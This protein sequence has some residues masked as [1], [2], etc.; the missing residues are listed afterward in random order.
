M[1]MLKSQGALANFSGVSFERRF[2]NTLMN[3]TR[4]KTVDI[5][6]KN[7]SQ[8]PRE[9]ILENENKHILK[10]YHQFPFV[11]CYDN[12]S[13]MDFKLCINDKVDIFIECKYQQ[14]EGSVSSKIPYSCA[15]LDGLSSVDKNQHCVYLSSGDIFKKKRIQNIINHMQQ[16]YPDIQFIHVD[17]ESDYDALFDFI[18]DLSTNEII[19]ETV[20]DVCRDE[21]GLLNLVYPQPQWPHLGI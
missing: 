17:T 8:I 4:Y 2:M 7:K 1:N 10:L 18:Y 9:I 20:D 12:K 3:T 11:D 19:S 5:L 6:Y 15:L 14:S 16:Q 13:Q 21:L